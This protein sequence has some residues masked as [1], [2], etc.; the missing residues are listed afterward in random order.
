MHGEISI[1]RSL[2]F[3]W[4]FLKGNGTAHRGGEKMGFRVRPPAV[5]LTRP[6]LG[7]SF[8]SVIG[9]QSYLPQGQGQLYN[10]QSPCN[11]EMWD[12]GWGGEGAVGGMS[13][14]PTCGQ[15]R[16]PQGIVNSGMEHVGYLDRAGERTPASHPNCTIVLPAT[17]LPYTEMPW[18]GTHLTLTLPMLMPRSQQV[19]RQ[20]WNTCFPSLVN[21]TWWST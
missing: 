11:M 16:N 19:Q 20:Q 21:A 18:R 7:S 8:P 13:V 9:G 17:T 1:L 3:I 12:P 15:M 4:L 14:S 6:S 2:S 5:P 10:F